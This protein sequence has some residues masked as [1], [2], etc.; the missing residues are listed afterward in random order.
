MKQIVWKRDHIKKQQIKLLSVHTKKVHSWTEWW[1]RGSQ[2]KSLW[3]CYYG[4]LKRKNNHRYKL[5]DVY[6]ILKGK[7]HFNSCIIIWKQTNQES[8][9]IDMEEISPHQIK[10]W[11]RIWTFSVAT[12]CELGKK[13]TY[14]KHRNVPLP[15]SRSHYV[16]GAFTE[17]ICSIKSLIRVI[18][19]TKTWDFVDWVDSVRLSFWSYAQK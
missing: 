19:N 4:Y 2:T 8:D 16:G 5:I 14:I 6:N 15:K 13:L 12:N 11:Q 9:K 1:A 3:R 17:H 10:V 7:K 18:G